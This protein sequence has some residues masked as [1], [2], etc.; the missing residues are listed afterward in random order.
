MNVTIDELVIPSRFDD[1]A[2]RGAADD[3]CEMAALTNLVEADAVGDDDLAYSAAD[4]LPEWN[5]PYEPKRAWLARVPSAGSSRGTGRIVGRGLYEV[6]VAEEAVAA[7]IKVEVLPEF[8]GRGIGSALF[9]VLVDHAR[10]DGRTVL[11][12]YA[13]GPY[14]VENAPEPERLDSPTGFGA[15]LRSSPGTSF[16]LARGFRLEQVERYSRLRLPVDDATLD[17]LRASARASAGGDYRIVHWLGATPERWRG[18]VAML[19]QRMSTDAPSAGLDIAEDPW[20]DARVIAMDARNDASP[21]TSLVTAVEHVPSGT[22]AGFTELSIPAEGHFPV[23]QMDTLVL[24]EHRGHRLGMLLKLAGIDALQSQRPGHP[25]ITTFNAEEN[26]HMLSVNE[27]IGF[28]A[29]GAEG[30]W[31][32]EL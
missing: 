9:D 20:D 5:D 8:R 21:R 2:T 19:H 31:R 1:P 28:V 13:L 18:D 23:A 7:W 25:S 32:R 4:L 16:L 22:L 24:R 6:E 14:P 27:A 12:S 26:R 11:Q 10:I 15:V 30:A 3:F 29:V 17:A